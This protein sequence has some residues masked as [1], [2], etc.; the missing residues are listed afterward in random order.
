MTGQIRQDGSAFTDSPI[1][2]IRA[3]TRSWHN[4]PVLSRP[5][6]I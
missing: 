6:A 1:I 4:S 3:T 2:C 5:V